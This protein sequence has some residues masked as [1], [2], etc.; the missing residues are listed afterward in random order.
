MTT[1]RASVEDG[2][3]LNLRPLHV[4][5]STGYLRVIKPYNGELTPGRESEDFQRA[6]QGALPAVLVTTAAGAYDDRTVGG[7]VADNVFE[8]VLLVGSHNLRSPEARTRGDGQSRDPGIY[9]IIEDIRGRLFN[10]PLEGA[11]GACNARPITED[12]VLRSPDRSI[13]ALTYQIRTDAI[14][15][16]L[17]DE[18]G[19]YTLIQSDINFPTGD[20]GEPANP[21]VEF[22]QDVTP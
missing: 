22:D 15:A 10:R 3:I 11:I 20:P 2:V 1:V 17:E 5:E 9:Q 12:S 6:T 7:R 4:K 18:A 13:W 21:V 14:E 16:P 8:I 19:D